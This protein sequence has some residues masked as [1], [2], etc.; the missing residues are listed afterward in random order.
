MHPAV[1]KIDPATSELYLIPGEIAG[2]GNK[3]VTK[4]PFVGS[5]SQM[6]SVVFD[7]INEIILEQLN[8][9]SDTGKRLYQFKEAF[10]KA[11]VNR[12]T[13]RKYVKMFL[14]SFNG[15]LAYNSFFGNQNAQLV[16]DFLFGKAQT[17]YHKVKSKCNINGFELRMNPNEWFTL[18][19]NRGYRI[20]KGNDGKEKKVR[21]AS[22]ELF[23]RVGCKKSKHISWKSLK[24]MP[25]NPLSKKAK[26]CF[27]CKGDN[28]ALTKE[29]AIKAGNLVKLELDMDDLSFKKAILK[30][31]KEKGEN[32]KAILNWK[33]KSCSTPYVRSYY[34]VAYEA[35]FKCKKCHPSVNLYGKLDLFPVHARVRVKDL[36]KLF[37]HLKTVSSNLDGSHPGFPHELYDD[38]ESYIN[39]HCS[40]IGKLPII[41][42]N[43]LLDL[44][45][46]L[47]KEKYIIKYSKEDALD[48]TLSIPDDIREA[49]LYA[50]PKHPKTYIT[51]KSNSLTG[52]I[53]PLTKEAQIH[54]LTLQNR[55]GDKYHGGNYYIGAET[56]VWIVNDKL[57]SFLTGHI[58]IL[59]RNKHSVR[60]FEYKP[61]LLFKERGTYIH[62]KTG[63]KITYNRPAS[64]FIKNVIQGVLYGALLKLQT[65]VKSSYVIFNKDGA[66]AFDV[67]IERVITKWL[68]SENIVTTTAW[69]KYNLF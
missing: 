36:S 29:K 18:V 24:G 54:H 6:D 41:D 27:E 49:I 65:G 61:N 42:K 11:E 10:T 28:Q 62:H 63:K 48:P 66:W 8:H 39:E 67:S 38:H 45:N 12:D 64:S 52:A 43:A 37:A 9:Y 58:D 33:C 69:D 60:V 51:L 4:N 32:T 46:K 59:K 25:E 22:S 20:V 56:N 34:G 5:G 50:Q 35:A 2:T 17:S 26:G 23:V 55:L 16:Y 15:Q 31:F 3:K 44:I 30:A 53:H 47:I 19:E 7:K 21:V 68:K 13:F 57:K 1:Q 40:E 14:N